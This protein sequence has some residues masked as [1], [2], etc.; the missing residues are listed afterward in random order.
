MA[1]HRSVLA[2]GSPAPEFSLPDQHGA[3]VSL[4]DYTGRWV[5]VWWYVKAATPG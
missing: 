4:E 3:E 2:E 1:Y 5:L